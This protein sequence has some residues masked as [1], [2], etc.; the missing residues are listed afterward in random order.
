M[1]FN[2]LLQLYIYTSYLSQFTALLRL[3]LFHILQQIY[4]KPSL[5]SSFLN[6]QK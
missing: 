5:I 1:D 3:T 4:L 2:N 6:P